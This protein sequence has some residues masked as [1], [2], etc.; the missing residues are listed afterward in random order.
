[1]L[2]PLIPPPVT[3]VPPGGAVASSTATERREEKARK[4]ARQS[5]FVIRP[6]G[7]SANDWFYPAVGIVGVLA[8]LL[9]A[10]GMQPGRR[11]RYALVE[12]YSAD[13]RRARPRPRRR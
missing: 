8:V 5:A 11:A 2:L 10:A 1:M 7:T 9:A 6:A 4:H 13:E 3:P 12:A